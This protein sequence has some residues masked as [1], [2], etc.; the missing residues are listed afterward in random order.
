MGRGVEVH[1]EQTEVNKKGK[2]DQKLKSL[3]EGIF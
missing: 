2:G 3:S 1:V